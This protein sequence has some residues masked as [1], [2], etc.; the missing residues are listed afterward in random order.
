MR[1]DV[2]ATPTGKAPKDIA[3]RCPSWITNWKFEGSS[4]PADPAP[5]ALEQAEC[6]QSRPQRHDGAAMLSAQPLP[7]DTKNSRSIGSSIVQSLAKVKEVT[8]LGK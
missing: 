1:A 6:C 5:R 4:S 7:Q 2:T 3:R 8:N